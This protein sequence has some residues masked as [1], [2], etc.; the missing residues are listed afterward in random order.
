MRC[1]AFLCGECTE[2]LDEA[3]YCAACVAFLQ[4]HGRPSRALGLTLALEAVALLSL[5]LGWM[6]LGWVEEGLRST[7]LLLVVLVRLPLL[8]GL[9]AGVGLWVTARERRRGELSSSGRRW[10][11]GARG[12]AW[13]CLA[14]VVL[15]V[16]YLLSLFLPGALR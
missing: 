3:A 1:G 15:E 7:V 8:T 6:P 2:L 12:L 11:Q 14:Y 5:P 9:A 13:V 4:K 16:A 10:A